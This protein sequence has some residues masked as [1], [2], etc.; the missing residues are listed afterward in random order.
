MVNIITTLIK[1]ITTVIVAIIA[2]FAFLLIIP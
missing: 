1:G 2:C